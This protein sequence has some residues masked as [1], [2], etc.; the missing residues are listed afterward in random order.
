MKKLSYQKRLPYSAE[1]LFNIITDVEKYPEFIPGCKSVF[2]HEKKEREITATFE[3]SAK[4][5]NKSITLC[6]LLKPYEQINI[7]LM[8]GPFKEL[9]AEWQFNT[10][11]VNYCDIVLDAEYEFESKITAMLV[12]PFI[13]KAFDHFIELICE[14][15]D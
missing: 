3:I 14:Q 10:I 7:L 8:K 9:K 15:A 13:S 11:D 4:G 5:F 12:S 6:Y 2:I 1:T